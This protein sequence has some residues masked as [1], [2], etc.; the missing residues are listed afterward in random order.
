MDRD[1][2]PRSV[3]RERDVTR[4]G[5]APQDGRRPAPP[6]DERDVFSRD[7]ELPRGPKRERIVVR[8]R[9]YRLRGSEVRT[10]SVVG[11][12]RVVAADQLRHPDDGRSVLSKDLENLK[13]LGL[14]R[15][16]PYVLGRERT[17]LV[18]LTDQGRDVLEASR[19][20]ND[21]NALQAFYAGVSKPRELAHDLRVPQA[22]REAAEQLAAEGG[23]IRRVVL[24]EELKREYQSFLQ[25]P[26]RDRKC[27]DGRPGRDADEVARWAQEHHLPIVDGCVRF[28]D[29]RLEYETR[30]GRLDVRD[31][32]VTTPHYRG[33]H[34]ATKA[35]SGFARYRAVGARL[36]GGRGAARGGRCKEAHLAEEMLR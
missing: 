27:S 10:L 20:S 36:C 8:G 9:E 15:T 26:N 11:A 2:D 14:A 1:L 18:T 13:D 3:E 32:E 19:R 29:V 24:E 31:V 28:P 5:S 12:F 4:G 23:R 21:G 34:A 25:A 22:Y 30:D 17:T 35:A 33:A 6:G 7:L 16:E